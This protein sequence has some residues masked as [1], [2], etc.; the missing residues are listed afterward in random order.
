ME[1]VPSVWECD[2]WSDCEGGED[3]PEGPTRAVQV[4]HVDVL[5]G[6]VVLL[7]LLLPLLLQ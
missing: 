7:R 3:E 5:V 4:V 1:C 6:Q 2:G